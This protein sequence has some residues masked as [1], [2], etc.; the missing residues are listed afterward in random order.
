M[1][2]H[3]LRTPLSSMRWILELLMSQALPS[4]V[5]EKLTQVYGDNQ[6][7]ILWVNDLLNISRLTQEG[8]V[9]NPTDTD[10]SEEVRKTIEEEKLNA[11]KRNVTVSFEAKTS[12]P[13]IFVD[14]KRLHDVLKNLIS[15]AVKYNKQGGTVA[16]SIEHLGHEVSL[17]VTDTGIGIP[18]AD[19]PHIFEKFFRASNVRTSTIEGTGLGMYVVE[20]FVHGWGGTIYIASQEGKGTTVTVRLPLKIGATKVQ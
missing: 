7:M 9:E 18:N 20:S 11:A 8:V 14:P 13:P 1:A 10:I 3:Q 2:A 16:I 15:N 17:V 19:I 4:T 12:V 6:R 5:K